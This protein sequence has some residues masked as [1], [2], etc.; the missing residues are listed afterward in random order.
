MT[1]VLTFYITMVAVI[2]AGIMVY[3]IIKIKE[4][5]YND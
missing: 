2:S 1:G 3:F 4:K 5:Y